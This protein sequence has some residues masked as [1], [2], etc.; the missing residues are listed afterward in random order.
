MSKRSW[1]RSLFG[2]PS[3]RT[4]RKAPPR[5]R[6]DF[7]ILEDR[8]V[9]ST[10]TPSV[11]TDG[12]AGS[13][14]LRAA[15]IAF[16]ADTGTGTDTINL[17]S[18][19]Y[20]LT[21]QNPGG[22]H[23]NNAASG[24][25]NVTQAAHVLIIQGQVDANGNP[26]SIIDATGLGDRVF[27]IAK[28]GTVVEFDNVITR[29]GTAQDDGSV[30]AVAGTT[31]AAGGAILNNGGNLT[32]HNVVLDSNQA[33]AGDNLPAMGGA[34]DSNGGSV[35]LINTTFS[36]NTAQGGAN[37]SGDPTVNPVDYGQGGGLYASGTTITVQA[38]T[39][40]NNQALGGNEPIFQY[41]GITR[42]AGGGQGGGLYVNGG[43]TTVQAS[44]F[45]NNGASGGFDANVGRVGGHGIGVFLVPVNPVNV[46]G[47]ISD[48]PTQGYGLG[49][50]V[51]A[52]GGTIAVASST[53]AN[54]TAASG[55]YQG[56]LVAN[57]RVFQ[58][59]ALGGGLYTLATTTVAACTFSNNAGGGVYVDS[60][61]PIPNGVLESLTDVEAALQ[62][63]G[64]GS[65]TI[66]N[67]IVASSTGADVSAG[68]PMTVGD[69]YLYTG[70]PSL[71]GTVL[72]TGATITGDHNLIQDGS[73]GVSDTIV[74]APLLSAL[75]N[76]GG[77]TRTVG[78]LPGS[79]ALGAGVAIPGITTDQ[80]GVARTGPIDIGAFQSQGFTVT[81]AGGDGQSAYVNTVFLT[82]LTV[83]VSSQDGVPVAGGVVTF[84]LDP[85]ATGAS[86][87]FS[88]GVVTIASDGSA[89]APTLP[90]A[91]GIAG[92]YDWV[93]AT[94][95]RANIARFTLT[96]LATENLITPTSFSDSLSPG[97]L[98]AAVIAFNADPGAA[99]DTINLLAG[100]YS[101]TIPGGQLNIT[102]TAHTLIIQGQGTTGASATI[103]DASALGQR[104]F[105]IASGTTVVLESLVIKGGTA[106]GGLLNATT[107][108]GI[109]DH[110][111]NL[112]IQDVVFDSD[113]AKG[114]MGPPEAVFGSSTLV[115]A[116]QGFDGLGGAIYAGV[117]SVMSISDTTF[118][119]NSATGGAGGTVIEETGLAPIQAGAG[120][121]GQGGAI[122]ADGASITLNNCTFSSNAADGGNAS[123]LFGMDASYIGG[124]GGAADGGALFARNG[125]M[126]IVNCT[127]AANTTLGGNGSNGHHT[128]YEL[129]NQ[130]LG[131]GGDGGNGQG[132]GV[133][134]ANESI[135]ITNSTFS[136]NTAQ[137]GLKGLGARGAVLLDGTIV[138]PAPDGNPGTGQGGGLFNSGTLT[139]NNT[140]V[141]GS[142]G[143][144][145]ALSGGTPGGSHNLIQDGS[146][147]L[148]DTVA[149]DPLLGP[150]GNYGGPTQTMALLPGSPAIDMGS[151]A[152]V[153]AGVTAD[154][155]G[156]PRV[157]NAIVDIGAF[158]SSGFT[159]AV[160]SGN[161]Q[162]TGVNTAFSAPLV[163]TVTAN[164]SSE[165]VAGG[166]VTFTPPAS[167]ASATLTGSPATISATGTA[168]VTA[169]AN[170]VTGGY[171]V[172]AKAAGITAPANFSLANLLPTVTTVTDAGGTYDGT[173]AFAATPTVTGAGT[174]S[175][176][177]TLDY[178]DNTTSTDLGKSAPVNAGHYTVTA[179]YA[180][181][182]T[183]VGS[184]GTAIFDVLKASSTTVATGG[185]F[186][187]D[188]S[189][190]SGGSA[191]VTGAGTITGSA[192]LSYSGDQVDAGSYTVIATYAGDANHLGSSGS[193][194]ITIGK[195]TSTTTTV[196]AAPFTY[197]GAT[198]NGG[199]GTV[200]GAGGL[201]TG[202]T[203]LTYTGDQIDAGTYYV[204]AHY[205][206]DANHFGS[207][208][209]AVALYINPALLT[210]T[211]MTGQSMTYGTAVPALTYTYT[212]LVNGETS[213]SFTG[214][215]ATSATSASSVG[216][217]AIIHGTLA[218]TG[219]YT[220]GTFNAGTLSVNPATL[221]IT[222][223]N[224]TKIFGTLKTFSATAFTE[225]GL[226]TANGDTISGVTETSTGT[227]AAAAV[228][229]DPIVA[230]AAT[231]TG[232]GNYNIKYVNGTLTVFPPITVPTAVQTAYENVNQTVGGISIGAG[233]SGNLTITLG[234]SHGTLTLGTT[235]G[236]T[237]TGNGTGSVT[238]IGTTANLNAALASLVYDGSLNYYGSDTLKVTL[239]NNGISFNASVAINVVSIAQQDANLKAQVNALQNAGV[240]TTKQATILLADLSL[241]GN[242]GD[243]GKIGSF[244]NDVQGYLNSRVLT[245]AQ[246]NALFGPANILLLG[247]RVEYG[248]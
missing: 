118:S 16:N 214:A 152:L 9:P 185:T 209:A 111:G 245:Q 31:A 178:Y 18:G 62:N 51:C 106:S 243:V 72:F 89:L 177:A 44:T 224:D 80:R 93:T 203:S 19:T 85:L 165:P 119:S 92:T 83:N 54:N 82:P 43:T 189:T 63:A 186:T 220:I 68:G 78:L 17:L 113:T 231:G 221:I 15:I 75:G 35:T 226:V 230:S 170:G 2:R 157:V 207:D 122:Y 20:A 176:S 188:G 61:G 200:T 137:G 3:T 204:T 149:A 115:T 145:V 164:N 98:R 124:D 222:A 148:A 4:I 140:I 219:N 213:A 21:I 6:L 163:V 8:T 235:S 175:G 218:A 59:E 151:N 116:Y 192:T 242:S 198:H 39:F 105:N 87:T 216:S 217:Y 248:S 90:A 153:P 50:G 156:L 201:L 183:H 168:S 103:I 97:S 57:P 193:A 102:S 202:A 13:G 146:G 84:A 110:G 228:G 182:A 94:T 211:P 210:V 45:A 246:A 25:L 114:R 127:F 74:A 147:G 123:N 5:R 7:E 126:T 232:L 34:L 174:I 130:P 12:G 184:S 41:D 76:Y 101:L 52:I 73:G 136:G 135:S 47:Y 227:A 95:T 36:S 109:L 215:L 239:T 241:Q 233:L 240:L 27:Q 60:R 166:Q 24:D 99:T 55:D 86:T 162:S 161:G 81:V 40:S 181:D 112:T 132:G 197:N 142:A 66:S 237:G 223:N 144:D 154:Q 141:A 128:L 29:G 70:P 133:S 247:L 205:A 225:T 37:T 179:T 71:A 155:R 10:L 229:T 22:V 134:A 67:T 159:I 191:V 30:G 14:S 180:G 125:T 160:S 58:Q 244:I 96:N 77:P 28:A 195:A 107:G 236:L 88:G 238:L 208:G 169:T 150:L 120:G 212:G 121:A 187:Y 194:T 56:T 108:G 172:L 46:I 167:G 196:G 79:P 199:S 234:V 91:N 26:T 131:T 33:L 206:G 173:T 23:E 42:Y 171:T 38:S 65:L 104:V 139:L 138:P 11:F 49:G 190:H 69:L 64:Q 117:G 100:T 53:F 1:I 158:E 32:F 48:D 143:G 129:A